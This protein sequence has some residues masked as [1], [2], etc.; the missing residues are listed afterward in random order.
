MNTLQATQMARETLATILGVT[1]E[2]IASCRKRDG[3]W[4]VELEVVETKA[5]IADNDLIA[6][7]QVD[8]D[9]D[10]DVTGYTRSGR[11]QRAHAAQVTA[12]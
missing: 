10:G 12:A 11:Y 2:T 3:G 1:V 6:I 8:L 4:T 9:T 5:R 7:Y